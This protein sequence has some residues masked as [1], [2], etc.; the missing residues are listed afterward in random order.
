MVQSVP[1]M[2]STVLWEDNTGYLSLDL[3]LTRKDQV[4][5]EVS[6]DL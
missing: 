3:S 1:K 4:R 2:L 6:V 5:F